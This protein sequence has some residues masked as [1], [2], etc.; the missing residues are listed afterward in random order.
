M[1]S[2]L[3]C[4]Q[5][6]LCWAL[7]VEAAGF[8]VKAVDI[9]PSYVEAINK[10]TLTS[11][12]PSLVSMLTKSKKLEAT[13]SMAEGAAF[14]S[15]IFVFVQ[16]PS[17]GN[18][19]HYDHTH[20][21][22]VLC[23]LNA[24]KV[25]D[26]HI[27]ICCTVM[28]GYC[29]LVA[30]SLLK[31]CTNVSVSYSPEFI[32]QGAIIQGTLN[33]DMALIGEG[34]VEAG[35]MMERVTKAYVANKAIKIFRLSPGSAEIAK[36]ALNSFVTLKIAFAVRTRERATHVRGAR[37][38]CVQGRMHD[39]E[40]GLHV[41][42]QAR[43]ARAHGG[44]RRLDKDARARPRPVLQPRHA[45]CEP[46]ACV[47]TR[48]QNFLG[49]LAVSAE[50]KRRRYCPVEARDDPT[51]II[52]QLAI[53]RA[54]GSDSRIG[55]KCLLPGYGFG[56]PCF[57]RDGRALAE[58][59]RQVSTDAHPLDVSI[60]NIPAVA[61]FAHARFQAQLL[62][63][64]ADALVKAGATA[65]TIVFD[66]VTFKPGCA[67]PIV[68]E[69]QK[70]V[71]ARWVRENSEHAVAIREQRDSVLTAVRKDVG[72]R[73]LYWRLPNDQVPTGELAGTAYVIAD[74]ELLPTDGGKKVYVPLNSNV[75][76]ALAAENVPNDTA[77]RKRAAG[78]DAP[79]S[80]LRGEGRGSLP[81]S[82][83]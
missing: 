14:A 7:C 9:F 15:N 73:F 48:A 82:F 70:L 31:D 21:N 27:V 35:A 53:A 41:R 76:N 22:D 2:I 61:N 63:E 57:P 81:T 83:S 6:G 77:S 8:A 40:R 17:S 55:T 62:V 64:R 54:I 59:A 46:I 47:R 56:G 58:V 42:A 1:R 19:Q 30:P 65:C 23:Q 51:R 71:V 39:T 16:T 79:I 13:L 29:D 68:L 11:Q 45:L 67:V 72:V 3:A 78:Q 80:E 33:P 69:S 25:K 4:I 36:L 75:V 24:L 43:E 44:A 18:D 20:L 60:A 32:A 38:R 34:S 12:E 10:R 74:D 26:K 49:D 28:P 50:A 52:D 66:D 37:V 5:L